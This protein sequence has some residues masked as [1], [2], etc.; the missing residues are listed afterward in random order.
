MKSSSHSLIPS[1]HVPLPS[2]ETLSIVILSQVQV[3]V[4][5]RL[6]VSQSVSVGVEPHLG[7]MTRHFLLF[8]S[9]GLVFCGAPSL[10]SGWVCLLYM[11]L[12]L[13]AQSFSGPSTLGLATI[14]YCLRF[15]TSLFVAS[16]DSQGHGG[17]IRP[18][19][20]TYYYSESVPLCTAAYIVSDNHGERLLFV[21]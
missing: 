2:Q 13:P 11:L 9:Y 14:S 18:S 16:Y 7:L 15:E 19:L 21:P 6:T 5:L 20:H 10:T 8:D 1:N 4:T 17:G 3:Q 12:A